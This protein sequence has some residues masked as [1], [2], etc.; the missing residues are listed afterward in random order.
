MQCWFVAAAAALE[1]SQAALASRQ[2]LV[3]VMM[4]ASVD[5]RAACGGVVCAQTNG[6][7]RGMARF[8]I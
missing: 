4:D 5:V 6:S 8:I 3:V 1:R 2:L 7:L